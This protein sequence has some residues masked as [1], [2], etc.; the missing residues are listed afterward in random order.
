MDQ[1]LEASILALA[2]SQPNCWGGSGSSMTG[3]T[4]QQHVGVSTC[5]YAP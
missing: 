1:G 3:A 4:N 2:H 5:V